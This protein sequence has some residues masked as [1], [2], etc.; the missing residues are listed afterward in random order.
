MTI[1]TI[2]AGIVLSAFVTSTTLGQCDEKAKAAACSKKQ[3]SACC[4]G[5]KAAKAGCNADA[6]SASCAVACSGDLAQLKGLPQMEYQVGDQRVSCPKAAAEMAKAQNAEIKFVVADKTFA[7]ENE[8]KAAY[9]DALDGYL[10]EMLTVRCTSEDE[11]ATCRAHGANVAQH[12]KGKSGYRL[13]SFS[14]DD[15]AAADEAAKKARQAAD[16]VEMKL[17]VGGE[18][19][20]CPIRAAEAAKKSGQKVDYCV[21]KDKTACQATARVRLATERIRAALAACEQSGGRL[22]SN[23]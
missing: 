6:K 19:Y 16:G 14:F 4:A 9:A 7:D 12:A 8:A 21:G 1:R 2:L 11:A 20:N 3:A 18:C 17:M 22:V 10:N 23:T 13:A 15:R 5:D